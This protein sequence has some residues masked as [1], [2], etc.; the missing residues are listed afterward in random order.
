VRGFGQHLGQDL[1]SLGLGERSVRML[2]VLVA[3]HLVEI[4]TGL[5]QE[6]TGVLGGLGLVAHPASK[7][8][9]GILGLE[10]VSNTLRQR[11]LRGVHTLREF[12]HR[13]LNR[14][15]GLCNTNKNT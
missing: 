2:G 14:V 8:L 12:V 3:Q 15:R 5:Q 11:R 6:V 7:L 10:N 4:A 1:G 13:V 9:Q